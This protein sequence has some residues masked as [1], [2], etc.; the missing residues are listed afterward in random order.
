MASA[1]LLRI[2]VVVLS[3]LC[4]CNTQ[5]YPCGFGNA[6][7]APELI[8]AYKRAQPQL[9]P[10]TF[11]VDV[12]ACTNGGPPPVT[13]AETLDELEL[14]SELFTSSRIRFELRKF[15]TPRTCVVEPR[16]APAL[17]VYVDPSLGP[18]GEANFPN[19]TL[20]GTLV[21]KPDCFPRDGNLSGGGTTFPHELGHVF[22][23]WHTHRGVEA[24]NPFE[25]V[26]Q[27]CNSPCFEPPGHSTYLNGDLCADTIPAFPHAWCLTQ[28]TCANITG[29]ANC[30]RY[31]APAV[32]CCSCLDCAAQRQPYPVTLDLGRVQI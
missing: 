5:Q 18:C 2:A 26:E 3:V 11:K 27:L 9:L 15:D 28:L 29:V 30:N 10:V 19:G 21:V 32:N 8:Q 22:G 25:S 24:G 12:T 1:F 20:N 16:S 13:R 17:H 7:D 4:C 6:C 23:L 31:C 14:A